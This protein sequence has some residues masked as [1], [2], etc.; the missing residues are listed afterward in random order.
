MSQGQENS[1]CLL[2][3]R[4]FGTDWHEYCDIEI[5]CAG[6]KVLK[7]F[8]PA[9][10][11]LPAHPAFFLARQCRIKMTAGWAPRGLTRKTGSYPDPAHWP[12][13]TPE[14]VGSSLG[15]HFVSQTAVCFDVG[16]VCWRKVKSVVGATS[17]ELKPHLATASSG[18]CSHSCATEG[19]AKL[20]VS[21]G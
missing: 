21:P 7:I 3:E 1:H 4:R 9:V 12:Q 8:S 13:S 2:G 10:R 6:A 11:G 16:S 18:R 14:W 20:Q 17:G 19:D 5:P 15:L